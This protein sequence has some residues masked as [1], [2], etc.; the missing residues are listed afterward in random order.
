MAKGL[1]S[2]F[3]DYLEKQISEKERLL[4]LNL[5]KQRAAENDTDLQVT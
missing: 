3:L 5:K 1:R 2:N 4:E